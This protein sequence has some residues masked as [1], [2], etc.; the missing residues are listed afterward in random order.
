M[1]SLYNHVLC[2]HHM[3]CQAYHALVCAL[4][5]YSHLLTAHTHT[6][7]TRAQV[8]YSA[9]WSW[10]AQATFK[11]AVD[12]VLQRPQQQLPPLPTVTAV[13]LQ[14]QPLSAEVTRL[15]QHWAASSG[16]SLAVAR[17]GACFQLLFFQIFTYVQTILYHT[18]LHKKYSVRGTDQLYSSAYSQMFC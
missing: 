3:A 5:T 17:K 11:A 4:H 1:R 13:P 15:L 6:L 7:T 10:R 14:E 8:W 16:V 2:I 18:V 12:T 9:S